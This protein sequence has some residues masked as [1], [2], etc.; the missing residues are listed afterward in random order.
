MVLH[1]VPAQPAAAAWS[2]VKV[3]ALA[4]AGSATSEVRAAQSARVRLDIADRLTLAPG[5]SRA[6]DQLP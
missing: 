3:V 2:T 5:G 4:L 1:V 6:P